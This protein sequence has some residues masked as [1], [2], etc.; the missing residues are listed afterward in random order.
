[1]RSLRTAL[2]FSTVLLAASAAAFAGAAAASEAPAAT[3]PQVPAPGKVTGA[4]A[5]ALAA[6]GARV[7]DVRTQE[8]FASGHVPGALLIP[9]EQVGNRIA[10]I[11]PTTTPVIVYCR[12]GRRSAVAADALR[13]AGFTKVYDMQAVTAWPGELRK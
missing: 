10:E 2:V 13:K 11:G 3:S 8:E 12:S 6:A 4:E 5:R 7:V 1:M 9:Y